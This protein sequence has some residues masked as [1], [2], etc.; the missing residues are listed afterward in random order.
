MSDEFVFVMETISEHT[1]KIKRVM[2]VM[3]K[4]LGKDFLCDGSRHLCA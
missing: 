4:Q 2:A 3:A 1:A